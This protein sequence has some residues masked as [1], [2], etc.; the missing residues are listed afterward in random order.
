MKAVKKFDSHTEL[1]EHDR[2]IVKGR[3]LGEEPQTLEELGK[4]L[5]ISLERVRH[6]E[7]RALSRIKTHMA[8]RIGETRYAWFDNLPPVV[9]SQAPNLV[10]PDGGLD[11]RHVRRHQIQGRVSVVRMNGTA[12]PVILIEALAHPG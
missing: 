8:A 10:F 2:G 4:R 1:P 12:E 7:Q 6:L 3:W 9:W 5:G 11:S